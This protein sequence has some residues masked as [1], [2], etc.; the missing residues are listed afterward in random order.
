[1]DSGLLLDY[2][3]RSDD[4][5]RFKPADTRNTRQ[6]VTLSAGSAYVRLTLSGADTGTTQIGGVSICAQSSESACTATPT[7]ITFGGSK[8][9]AIPAGASVVSDAVRFS[10]SA[11]TT[12]LIPV[13]YTSAYMS[14]PSTGYDYYDADSTDDVLTEAPSS[15]TPYAQGQTLT[16]IEVGSPLANVYQATL[17][18]QPA[19][20]TYYGRALTRNAGAG[21][22][23][24]L[25]QWD[26]SND[27]LY[28]NVGRKPLSRAVQAQ[29][30][31]IPQ[32]LFRPQPQ[33]YRPGSDRKRGYSLCCGSKLRRQPQY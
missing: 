8:T 6:R 31:G 22:G 26:W 27:N 23:V 19:G 4:G 24:G 2:R 12:Y 3:F 18:Q 1:M 20:V 29:E 28:V 13:C 14:T 9:V 10:T 33:F 16:K 7:T 21:F 32:L 25:N 17:A 15:Y 11:F 30:E 5:W